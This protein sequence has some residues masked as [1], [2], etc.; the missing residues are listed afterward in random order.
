M[1]QEVKFSSRSEHL[2]VNTYRLAEVYRF[3]LCVEAPV[4]VSG[5]HTGDSAICVDTCLD[6]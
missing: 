1:T 3:E 5:K 4:L 2:H 6:T